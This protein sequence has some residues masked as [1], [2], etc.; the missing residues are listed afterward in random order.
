MIAV[1]LL[2]RIFCLV[3]LILCACVQAHKMSGTRHN[4]RSGKNH[5]N[6]TKEKTRNG[7]TVHNNISSNFVVLKNTINI[8]MCHPFPPVVRTKNAAAKYYLHFAAA[9]RVR[10]TGG[11]GRHINIY[12]VF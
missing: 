3:L 6:H 11:K 5:S 8:I 12:C 7:K 10:T 2:L 4:I 9:F 1:V